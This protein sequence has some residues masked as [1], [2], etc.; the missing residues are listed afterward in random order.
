MSKESTRHLPP[1]A[2]EEW[3]ASVSAHLGIEESVDIA[4]VLD[5]TRDV[6]H[7]VARPAAPLTTFALGL[8][9][10]RL[11]AGEYEPRFNQLCEELTA[12][13]AGESSEP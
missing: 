4:M 1:E 9:L 13:A 8:A 11:P 10:G 3:M 12:L 2:L 6:A 7:D 5:L